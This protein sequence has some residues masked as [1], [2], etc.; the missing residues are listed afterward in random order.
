MVRPKAPWRET[1]PVQGAVARALCAATRVSTPVAIAG[2]LAALMLVAAVDDAIGDRWTLGLFYYFPVAFA[3]WRLGRGL[4]LGVGLLCSAVWYLFA[5]Q[6]GMATDDTLALWWSIAAQL[7]SY[8]VVAVVVSEM[9]E[10]FERERR[11]AR[12]CHLTGA[13]S[14]RAFR[15]VLDQ[16]VALA[17]Q[18]GAPLGLV[19]VDMDDF[20][21]LNDRRGHAAGDAAL[22]AFAAAVQSTLRDGDYFARTG[23]D[24]FVVLLT[25]PGSDERAV[26]DHIRRTATTALGRAEI[27]AGCSMGAILVPGDRMID[28]GDLM[29]RADKAMYEAKRAG[30]GGLCVFEVGKRSPLSVAA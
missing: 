6:Q 15:D 11:L 3:A 25:G 18:R 19:Y 30:K 20:K 16:E 13:L 5:S 2:T 26:I 8:A 1:G 29:R 4:A 24:E 22:E 21:A 12:Y 23:G 7:L 17:Q 10:L 28:A 9:R 14:G 27:A